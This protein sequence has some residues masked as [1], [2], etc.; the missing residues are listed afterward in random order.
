MWLRCGAG[1]SRSVGAI[2]GPERLN[3]WVQPQGPER[4]HM[5]AIWGPSDL[6]GGAINRGRS[7]VIEG[8]VA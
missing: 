5:V 1:A 4:L 7:A 2:S 8:E 6:I 3:R